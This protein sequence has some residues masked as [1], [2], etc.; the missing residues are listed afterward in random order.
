P[1]SRV[2]IHRE[3]AHTSDCRAPAGVGGRRSRMDRPIESFPGS[4]PLVRSR[5]NQTQQ[6]RHR[7]DDVQR[8]ARRAANAI[9]VTARALILTAYEIQGSQLVGG[10][11]WLQTEQFDVI[12]KAEGAQL[13]SS[14]IHGACRSK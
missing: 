12:A 8:A 9:G 6:L 4:R 3:R 7:V 10:P 14:S 5:I 2:Q 11:T 13:A 1:S